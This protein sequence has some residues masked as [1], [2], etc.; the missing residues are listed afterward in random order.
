M[1]ASLTRDREAFS[2]DR[3]SVSMTTVLLAMYTSF[4]CNGPSDIGASLCLLSF[5]S[6]H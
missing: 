6:F 3:T 5:S 2:V 4:L 1:G